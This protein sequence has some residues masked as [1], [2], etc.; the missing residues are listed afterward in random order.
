MRGL[1]SQGKSDNLLERKLDNWV[2]IP[3]LQLGSKTNC[4][5][6]PECKTEI[7][8]DP[9][10]QCFSCKNINEAY[11]LHLKNID[12]LSS[13][14]HPSCKPL[15]S[16]TLITAPLQL[17]FPSLRSLGFFLFFFLF[18]LLEWRRKKWNQEADR[19]NCFFW[20]NT[21]RLIMQQDPQAPNFRK[22]CAKLA[23]QKETKWEEVR[24]KSNEPSWEIR[25]AEN[26]N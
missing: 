13:K 2:E 7:F 1:I 22:Y 3:E 8:I 10:W 6:N 17:P 4:S 12:L 25:A 5:L 19:G 15:F 21:P 26:I 18:P 14:E 9:H 16:S 23:S 24:L 11:P 20:L